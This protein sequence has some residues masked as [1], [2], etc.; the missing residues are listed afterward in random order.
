MQ[1]MAKS[2]TPFAVAKA[3]PLFAT[4]DTRRWALRIKPVINTKTGDKGN[5]FFN[6]AAKVCAI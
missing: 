5:Q 4:A 3:A 6:D 1:R 2:V